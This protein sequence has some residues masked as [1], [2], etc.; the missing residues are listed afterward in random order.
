MYRFNDCPVFEYIHDEF[1][2]GFKRSFCSQPEKR[3]LG[4]IENLSNIFGNILPLRK[5]ARKIFAPV[6]VFRAVVF[7][8]L[9]RKH[10]SQSP[11]RKVYARPCSVVF[12]CIVLFEHLVIKVPFSPR[13]LE[14]NRRSGR[15]KPK[16]ST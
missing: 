4:S 1:C 16:R 3:N 10:L 12:D 7:V 2:F 6:P 15:N 8:Y 11:C 5:K 14:S 13:I 9:Y